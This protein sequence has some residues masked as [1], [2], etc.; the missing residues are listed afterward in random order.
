M[1]QQASRE[2][3]IEGA[4][5]L[6]RR[7]RGLVGQL[8]E[9]ASHLAPADRALVEAVYDRGMSPAEFARAVKAQ[10]RSLRMRVSRIVGRLGSPLYRYVVTHRRDWPVERRGVADQII[11]RGATQRDTAA[12]LGVSLH[13]VRQELARLRVMADQEQL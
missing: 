10:P 6:L 12:R 7:Q 1:I 5:E 2:E 3:R 4:S 11:L 9:L 8:L 13:R